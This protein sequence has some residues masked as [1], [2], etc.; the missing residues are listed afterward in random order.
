M[1]VNKLFVVT[2]VGAESSGK[3]TLAIRLAAHFAC[4][5]VPEYAR[6]YL[7][8]L[9]R[10]YNAD[11]LSVIA[12]HQWERILETVHLQSQIFDKE[13][14]SKIVLLDG[15]MMNLRLWARIKYGI[16]IPVVE[17]ALSDDIS[18]LYIL[19]RPVREWAMDPL[20]EAPQILDRAWIYNQYLAELKA[21]SKPIEIVRAMEEEG[22]SRSIEAIISGRQ[23]L[24]LF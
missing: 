22:V 15:G 3:T 14:K 7:E 16:S 10:P 24:A 12:T 8:V 1:A 20:R 13:S 11:D 9:D 23:N 18:D 21:G 17:Q 4:S 5:W 19:C 2:I 6:E